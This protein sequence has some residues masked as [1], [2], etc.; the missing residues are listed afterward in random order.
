MWDLVF[1]II[2]MINIKW[3]ENKSSCTVLIERTSI[4]H[5]WLTLYLTFTMH[6]V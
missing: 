3:T 2:N 4:M 5:F 6:I 1:I